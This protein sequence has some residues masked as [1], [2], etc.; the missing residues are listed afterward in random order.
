MNAGCK[1]AFIAR[2]GKVLSSLQARPEIV[3]KDLSE[4]VDEVLG[5]R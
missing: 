5:N 1:A 3:G 4:V 2:E